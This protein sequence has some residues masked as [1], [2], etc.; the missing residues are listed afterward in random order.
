MVSD[1]NHTKVYKIILNYFTVFRKEPIEPT[2][3]EVQLHSILEFHLKSTLYCHTLLPVHFP[4]HLAFPRLQCL[5]IWYINQECDSCGYSERDDMSFCDAKCVRGLVE[6]LLPHLPQ[7]RLGH[8]RTH[9]GTKDGIDYWKLDQL[10]PN[11][12]RV[13]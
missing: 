4:L 1:A 2:P 8:V 6:P 9:L 7:L 10:K 13:E 3:V 11:I 5:Q 12:I